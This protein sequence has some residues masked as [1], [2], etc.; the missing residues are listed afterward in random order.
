L[1]KFDVTAPLKEACHAI[2]PPII[3][4]IREVISRFDPEFQR[5]VLQNI[6]LGGG[7]SQL[8]GLDGLIEEALEPYGGGNVTRVYD[9]VFAGAVGALKLALAMPADYWETL[10]AKDSRPGRAAA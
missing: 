2:V 7:G 9:S 10:K 6:L 3:E 4:G 1:A 8:K 5:S